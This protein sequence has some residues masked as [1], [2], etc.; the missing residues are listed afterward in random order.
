MDVLR[1]GP[2]AEVV[3]PASLREEA[4]ISLRLALNAY[5]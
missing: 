3:A 5:E 2:E 4:K 1:Y